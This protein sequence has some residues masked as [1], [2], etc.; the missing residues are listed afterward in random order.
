[1][2][3]ISKV[4]KLNTENIDFFLEDEVRN[5][6]YIP[7]EMKQFWG[8]E[9]VLLNEI[10]T[11]FKKHGLKYFA[12]WGT[13]L[14]AVRHTGFI[15]WDDDLDI[16]MLREDYMKLLK[17]QD[18]HPEELPEGFEVRTFRNR[19]DIDYFH[20]VVVGSEHI[21]FEIS[22]LSKFCG[23]PYIVGIDIFVLDHKAEDPRD[24]TAMAKDA[25]YTIATADLIASGSVKERHRLA[26]YLKQITTLP[27][28]KNVTDDINL[29]PITIRKNLYEVVETMFASF[30]EEK[31]GKLIQNFPFGLKHPEMEIDEKEYSE[32]VY[33]PFE[34]STIPVPAH[35][36]RLLRQ[37]YRDYWRIRK[38]G[39]AH[40]YP[41]YTEQE[42]TLRS[43]PEFEFRGFK[44]D[45]SIGRSIL[46]LRDEKSRESWK[47][48]ALECVEQISQLFRDASNKLNTDFINTDLEAVLQI[49]TDAQQ[50]TI[51]L[52]G[53]IE[54]I[55]G[56][57][58]LT[59]SLL[60][61]VCEK[62]FVTYNAIASQ[63]ETKAILKCFEETLSAFTD[64]SKEI[65][66][67]LKRKLYVFVSFRYSS[68]SS[69]APE[70]EK[71]LN[72]DEADLLVLAIPY[73]HKA[74]DGRV[75]RKILDMNDYPDDLKVIRGEE[76]N[77]E[78]L[79]PD[80]IYIQ[81]PYDSFNP[82]MDIDPIW[83]S[84]NLAPFTE[85]LI[86]IPWFTTA[87]F[88]EDDDK[89]MVNAKHYI[90]MPGVLYSDRIILDSEAKGRIY[91][92]EL[93][94]ITGEPI[95]RFLS[96][97]I[98]VRDVKRPDKKHS[99][100]LYYVSLYSFVQ[101]G[102]AAVDKL[103]SNLEL[104]ICG[105]EGL[106]LTIVF[107]P[108][109][110]INLPKLRPMLW[111]KIEKEIENAGHKLKIVM[112]DRVLTEAD[113]DGF[114]AFYGDVCNCVPVFVEKN[115]PVMLTSYTS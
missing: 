94:K 51:D 83:Y 24:Q 77:L 18:D 16:L 1:M 66:D 8:A 57:G 17:L 89:D 85:E 10:D 111:E 90:N 29:D 65:D 114:T 15:P 74:Y 3:D 43:N 14:G 72:E 9:I 20:A 11:L 48:T 100:L 52:G 6:F 73:Y 56:E 42:K 28:A 58:T 71:C 39:G 25:L 34:F 78:I 82:V 107:D 70:Y 67:I 36:D 102:E 59:V 97:K 79:H 88:N 38:E 101:Y 110:R 87:D 31:S 91:A 99:S 45:P 13:L 22:H 7:A 64:A 21:S 26:E 55:K 33:L 2:D 103:K 63:E 105:P 115:K 98:T 76:I 23:C 47:N 109:V 104:L 4:Y 5:G 41:C 53:F 27:K 69:F 113:M 61:K 112:A 44:Y 92:G 30:S 40:E 54:Q 96:D 93:S 49:L 84:F 60:E 80:R 32:N 35:Y 106:D 46:E 12:D 95:D 108:A 68:W 75:I 50:L 81:F 19:D 37:K 62:I 86:Y